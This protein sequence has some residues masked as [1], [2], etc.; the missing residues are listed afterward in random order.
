MVFWGQF[1]DKKDFKDLAQSVTRAMNLRGYRI[2]GEI[3][4]TVRRLGFVAGAGG[5]FLDTAI[6]QKTGSLY[7]R[8]NQLSPGF[9]CLS[10]RCEGD[11]VGSPG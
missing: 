7:Y 9:T 2:T 4:S 11:G 6:S 5:S 8:R 1:S 3:P 10:S